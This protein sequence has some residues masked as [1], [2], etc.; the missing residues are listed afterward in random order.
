MR[1][2]LPTA[3]LRLGQVLMI[4]GLAS[5]A[6]ACGDGPICASDIS[7]FITTPDTGDTLPVEDGFGA[8]VDVTVRTNLRPGELVELTVTN[9]FGQQ[10][11][12]Q[13]VPVDTDG[14][15]VVPFVYLPGGRSTLQ[16]RGITEQCGTGEDFIDVEVV[17]GPG[18]DC[19]I[20]ARQAPLPN[21]AYAPLRVYNSAIDTNQD[22]D[23]FQGTF[24]VYAPNGYQVDLVLTDLGTGF[25]TQAGT[26]FSDFGVASY[27]MTVP[28]GPQS[29]VARCSSL[30]GAVSFTSAP[31]Q[32]H[33]DTQPPDCRLDAPVAGEEITQDMDLDGDPS[34]GLQL[35]LVGTARDTGADPITVEPP[36]FLVDDVRFD[37]SAVDDEGR[38][39]VEVTLDDL[40]LYFLGIEAQDQAGNV[41]LEF[42]DF[43]Y[44]GGS[45]I[46]V[47]AVTRSSVELSWTA[48]DPDG[49]GDPAVEYELRVALEPIDAFNFELVGERYEIPA[50]G[51]PG[52]RERVSVGGFRPGTAIYV[53]LAARGAFG[54]FLF[55]GEAGPIGLELDATPA[56]TPVA[57]DEGENGLGYQMAAG[58]F[59][60]DGFG[61]LAVAAPFKSVNGLGGAGAVYV[62]FGGPDGLETTPAVIIEGESAGAQAGNGLT[63]IRWDD[64]DID[65]LAIGAPFAAN[66]PGLVAVFLGGGA[67]WGGGTRAL[68]EGEVLIFASNQPGNWFQPTVVDG[69]EYPS[70]LGFALTRAHFDSDD[71]EDLVIS[72]PG[73][74]GGNGGVVVLYGGVSSGL[75]LLDSL[76]VEN[77]EVTAVVLQDPDP[78]SIFDTDPGAFFGHHVFPLGPTQG[79]A[80][81]DG[82]IGVAYTEKNAAV[83]F[84]GRPR[85]ATPGVTLLELDPARDLE[86]QRSSSDDRSSRYGTAMGSIDINGDGVRDIVVGM[87]RDLNNIGRI[88]IYR[89]NAVGVRDA[90]SVR[91]R[92]ITPGTS[93]CGGSGCGLGS[94]ILN[95]AASPVFPD[96]NGDGVEDLVIVGGMDASGVQL[97]A[98]FGGSLPP[99]PDLTTDSAQYVRYA[100][101][102][103]VA[104][105]RGD[106]DATPITAIWAG[107]VNDDALEDICW[108]DWSAQGRDGAFQVLYDDGQ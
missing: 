10:F 7:V 56:I 6:P 57:P 102:E 48:P 42:A 33:V 40:G 4:A 20:E 8:D 83:V 22:V 64:D 50:P 93:L 98:W 35:E 70:G 99:E 45:V 17:T 36:R 23:G 74:G 3:R 28:E 67:G 79:P 47:D 66:G 68:S 14:T 5:I 30:D 85:P 78:G 62:Y 27:T 105:A 80:D 103:F 97:M 77:E 59:N 46:T 54:S 63:T 21:P 92:S 11:Y 101:S 60:G 12:F 107:D 89:G 71:R 44:V 75:I 9:Q 26:R 2:E 52:T 51:A 24:D 15:A 100:P 25:E 13:T 55:L 84:R 86:L 69:I 41:C 38:S 61:D 88:E 81:P 72:T 32:V 106:S 39:A 37:G 58:D 73:G 31:F 29:L 49:S 76:T 87:W 1:E 104:G 90:S 94:A 95:N 18:T 82:D 16:A 19:F 53:G 65:D 108:A 34:N 96:L 43:F 91:L